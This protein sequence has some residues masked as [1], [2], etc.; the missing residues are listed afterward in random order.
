MHSCHS[1][2]VGG[3]WKHQNNPACT[4]SARVFRMLKLDIISE[5]KKKMPVELV[6]YMLTPVFQQKSHQLNSFSTCSHQF[7]SRN[8]KI[9][10]VNSFPTCLHQFASRN[11]KI[12]PVNSFSTC[13]HQFARRNHKITP[14]NSFST[15]SHQFAHR[16]HNTF[17]M[18]C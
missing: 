12:R 16:N 3:L 6:T 5:K 11:H 13:S 18:I 17:F 10:P 1:A 9:R 2:R 4:K 14:V 7:A 8:H 15:C